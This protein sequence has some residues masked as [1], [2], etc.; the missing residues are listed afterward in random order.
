M[1]TTATASKAGRR[2][3][4]CLAKRLA[5]TL[6]Q[7]PELGY[8]VCHQMRHVLLTCMTRRGFWP[9][10]EPNRLAVANGFIFWHVLA[11]TNDNLARIIRQVLNLP[12]LDGVCYCGGWVCRHGN[13]R[14]WQISPGGARPL[15][16]TG[17]RA[18]GI[19]CFTITSTWPPTTF[20]RWQFRK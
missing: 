19:G 9:C 6:I 11:F 15:L 10:A 13:V 14:H 5:K 2:C 17:Q 18:F 4:N 20:I 12:C 1:M 3:G 7:S 8:F 16:Q